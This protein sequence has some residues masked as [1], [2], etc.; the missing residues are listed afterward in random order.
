MR[1]QPQASH[2]VAGRYTE[3]PE[4]QLIESV[5]PASGEIIA[6]LHAADA[7]LVEQAV[8]AAQAGFAV[9]STTPA[10]ERGGDNAYPG[11]RRRAGRR[12]PADR[13]YR[14]TSLGRGR[15][16]GMRL[17]GERGAGRAAS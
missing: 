15:S 13:G 3:N 14:P 16:G 9:W 12:V 17:V 11:E 6:Q 2:F 4:G 10:A 8:A 1:A 7:A 5:Y